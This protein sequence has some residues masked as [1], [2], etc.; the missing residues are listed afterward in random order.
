MHLI[1]ENATRHP[2]R[3]LYGS[4]RW[5]NASRQF[6]DENPLCVECLKEG[7]VEPSTQTDHIIPHDGDPALFW[8]QANWQALCESHHSRKTRAE[9]EQKRTNNFV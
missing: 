4:R 8:D 2:H 6:L 7:T 3:N 9:V 5:R 1:E